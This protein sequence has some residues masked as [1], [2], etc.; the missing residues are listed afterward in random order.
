[1]L[2]GH[3]AATPEMGES[4]R[5]LPLAECAGLDE[6]ACTTCDQSQRS[7]LRGILL[8]A[9][10]YFTFFKIFVTFSYFISSSCRE[11]YN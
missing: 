2:S 3:S 1:M 8:S 5:L 11:N 10:L 4:L 9:P 6:T 7:H